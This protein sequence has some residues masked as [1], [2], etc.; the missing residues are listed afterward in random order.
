MKLSYVLAA[1]IAALSIVACEKEAAIDTPNG[2][3]VEVQTPGL[4]KKTFYAT[5]EGSEPATKALL[6][7]TNK[8][9]WES[10]DAISVFVDDN[11][12][13]YEMTASAEGASTG[14]TGTI[15]D[16][17]NYIAV[18]PY[19]AS[20]VY[21]PANAK[22][23]EYSIPSV[24]EATLDSFD[25]KAAI[26][27]ANTDDK[28]NNLTFKAAFALLK[29]SVD[30]DNVLAVYVENAT[31]PMSGSIAINT[32]AEVE[33]GSGDKFTWVSLKKSDG[34]ALAQG[35][36][37][38]VVRY[39]DAAPYET[40]KLTYVQD[41]AT[42]NTRSAASLP[43]ASLGRNDILRLGSLTSIDAKY[44]PAVSWFNYYQAC[45]NVTIGSKTI[46]RVI[47]GD[48]TLINNTSDSNPFDIKSIS[49]K[50][51]I[52][53]F[54]TSGGVFTNSTTIGITGKFALL[55][56]MSGTITITNP[57]K[58]W[59]L[60]NGSIALKGLAFDASGRTGG[61]FFSNTNGVTSN[62]EYLILDNCTFNGLTKNVYAPHSDYK[63]FVVENI[64]VVNCSFAYNMT[65]NIDAFNYSSVTNPKDL[66]SFSFEN[67]LVFNSNSTAPT[68]RV[69]VLA[70][71]AYDSES[72][73][74][75]ALLNSNVFINA[76]GTS[77][78][79]WSFTDVSKIEMQN[80]VFYDGNNFASNCNL[81]DIKNTGTKVSDLKFGGNVCIGLNNDKKWT[82][83]TGTI[84]SLDNIKS[85]LPSKKNTID[86][87]DVA[88]VFSVAPTIKDGVVSYTLMPAYANCG[89][90]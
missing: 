11:T 49:G 43:A 53:F 78:G 32:S 38:I 74:L 34:T 19:S 90:Q 6:Y 44:T 61:A 86:K 60:L 29:V 47:D 30:K 37:Y 52:Y 25:P 59:N 80:N 68:T 22:P 76:V 18:Y 83:S 42:S 39:L 24:Q 16:G 84:S 75:E 4:V 1:A 5:V 70:M 20:I 67:N 2:D 54:R 8:T 28:S 69:T 88:T 35:D 81:F 21:T 10:T 9:K 66:K 45:L 87:S 82:H 17:S 14:F 65:G 3:E 31:L 15:A 63:A 77:N 55:N 79:T 73:E 12:T 27:I 89:P 64:E 7:D 58:A 40:F 23:V 33:D 85:A 50:S 13:N 57:N 51:G 46:N 72:Y 36:Y 62:S 56:D 41:D 48:A 26:F 71:P